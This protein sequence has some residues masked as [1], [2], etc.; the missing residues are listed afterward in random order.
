MRNV[1]VRRGV[2]TAAA[3]LCFASGAPQ[4]DRSAKA[5]RP[6]NHSVTIDAVTYDVPERW[7]ERYVPPHERAAADTLVALPK[8]LCDNGSRIYVTRATREA[9]VR[10]AEAARKAGIRF[11]VDS[12]YRSPAYQ[13][14]V[15]RR[16]MAEGQTFHQVVRFVAPPG[17][18]PHHPAR[19]LDLVPRAARFVHTD[20]YK[21][22]TRHA[23]D[24]GFVESY[25][26]PV[27]KSDYDYWESW[28]WYYRE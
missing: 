1:R 12:G 2:L 25:P 7:C 13:K 16:R 8:D 10:M 21:W 20:A 28:H 14:R 22:L 15:I 11:R 19:A 17:F 9:F 5:E 4:A 23:A 18:S 24:F 27:E 3:A 26:K 6:C